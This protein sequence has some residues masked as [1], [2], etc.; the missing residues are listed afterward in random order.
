VAPRSQEQLA[1]FWSARENQI[2]GPNQFSP[3]LGEEFGVF[4]FSCQ[5]FWNSKVVF[6]KNTPNSM[7]RQ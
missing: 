6:M 2:Y 3:S 7:A 5:S 1:A 4:L